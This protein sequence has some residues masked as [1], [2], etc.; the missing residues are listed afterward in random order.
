MQVLLLLSL[1]TSLVDYLTIT[2]ET[3]LFKTLLLRKT[4]SFSEDIT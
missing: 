3:L 2:E 4:I 1:F